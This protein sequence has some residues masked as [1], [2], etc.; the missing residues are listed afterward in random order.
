MVKD[1]FSVP[2][3]RVVAFPEIASIS[4]SFVFHVFQ[5]IGVPFFFVPVYVFPA[6]VCRFSF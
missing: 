5:L 6:C 3:E 2:V 1:L 4:F